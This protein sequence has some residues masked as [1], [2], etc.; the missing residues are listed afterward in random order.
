MVISC[1]PVP[2]AVLSDR[3]QRPG[4]LRA[5]RTVAVILTA[6]SVRAIVSKAWER[7]A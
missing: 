7:D 5:S 4:N 6:D 1:L 3:C 2:P